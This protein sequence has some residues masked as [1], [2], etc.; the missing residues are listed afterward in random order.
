MVYS[1]TVTNH[2]GETID[3]ELASPGLTGLAITSI[4]GLTPSEANINISSVSNTDLSI[5]NSA[6]LKNRNIVINFTMWNYPIENSRLVMYRFFPIKQK[7]TMVFRTENHVVSTEGYVEKVS[8]NIFSEKETGQVSILCPD[9]YLYEYDANGGYHS[10]TLHG[11]TPLLWFDF[12]DNPDKSMFSN[13]SIDEPL[14]E[15]SSINYEEKELVNLGDADIGFT[16]TLHCTGKVKNPRFNNLSTRESMKIN[17][18]KLEALVGSGLQSGDDLIIC[19]ERG[20]KSVYLFRDG[21]RTSVISTLESYETWLTAR[22]GINRFDFTAD[23]GYE[24]M[25]VTYTYRI[26]YE[27]I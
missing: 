8:A 11:A 18:E 17:S 12:P 20:K 22:Q 2:V 23:E 4:D 5:F 7:I 16:M 15:F 3:L 24:N 27:G 21:A 10:D 1:V 19:T 13:E 25:S 9:P 6:N 14:I 26:A